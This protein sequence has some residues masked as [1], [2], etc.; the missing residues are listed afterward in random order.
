MHAAEAAMARRDFSTARGLLEQAAEANVG[1]PALLIKLATACR[2]GNDLAAALDATRHA[3]RAA[4][5]DFIAL[6]MYA[7]LLD[8]LDRPNAG[9]AW[10]HALAQR[11]SGPLPPQLC[12][13]VAEAQQRHD[14]WAARQNERLTAAL[15]PVLKLAD[16]DERD[17]LGR[18]R[19]NF[20]RE[21]QVFHSQP[22]HFYFPGL[23][24]YEFFP[25]SLFPWIQALEAQTDTIQD[26]FESLLKSNGRAAVPYIQYAEHL[27][28][29][30]WVKL[31]H[32]PNWSALHLLKNGRQVEPAASSC[33]RTMAAL[34]AVDQPEV[35]H[36][37][38]NAMFSILSPG[39]HIPPHHG[40]SNTRLICHLPLVVPDNCW[41]RV[42]AERRD[43]ARGQAFVFDDTIEHE[44]MNASTQPRVVLIF[45][46]WHP[47]L[48]KIE[49]KGVEAISAASAG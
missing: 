44:A 7:S 39:T 16:S 35:P 33:P 12:G 30:Q 31:N 2:A 28:L 34:C 26:E 27:P 40:V 13:A 43:W 45:D 32:N 38:P 8:R 24:T 36:S 9:E 42:G 18:F 41:F 4:P 25:R 10:G 23:R 49:R 17:R 37:S 20:M 48:S 3:L 5:R 19:R 11:P 22:T 6:L 29:D 21:S 47:D 14:A 1:D 15:G 46:I